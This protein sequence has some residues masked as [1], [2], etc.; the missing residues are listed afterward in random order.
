MVKKTFDTKEP[1][2]SRSL[3]QGGGEQDHSPPPSP[4]SCFSS[5]AQSQEKRLWNEDNFSR[6]ATALSQPMGLYGLIEGKG[7]PNADRQDS[8]SQQCREF[9]QSS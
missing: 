5:Q 4:L 9:A 6:G 2:Q 3:L 7:G 8:F 1:Y